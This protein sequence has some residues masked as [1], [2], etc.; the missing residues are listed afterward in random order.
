MYI[1]VSTFHVEYGE[2]E[3]ALHF[4]PNSYRHQTPD[5]EVD[6]WV[7][8]HMI[9][10][11]GV[12]AELLLVWERQQWAGT[13]PDYEPCLNN[14]IYPALGAFVY[15]EAIPWPTLPEPDQTHFYVPVGW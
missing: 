6:T 4:E 9:T 7:V 5:G 1:V 10:D 3:T 2:T 12:N 8:A 14:C 13:I 11:P 15:G